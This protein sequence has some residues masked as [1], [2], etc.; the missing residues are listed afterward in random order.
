MYYFYIFPEFKISEQIW[1]ATLARS[2]ALEFSSI[3]LRICCCFCSSSNLSLLSLVF[4]SSS[5][6]FIF[7]TFARS[8]L[9]VSS[10]WVNIDN[11]ESGS[12]T[13]LQKPASLL[14]KF[15]QYLIYDTF[16][17]YIWKCIFWK[18]INFKPVPENIIMCLL[19]PCGK[20]SLLPFLEKYYSILTEVYSST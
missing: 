13:T 8:T 1:I 7:R 9:S 10:R 16:I 20:M 11:Q 12:E 14:W 18:T 6:S 2:E 15:T 5:H 4:L 3:S 17:I 19:W